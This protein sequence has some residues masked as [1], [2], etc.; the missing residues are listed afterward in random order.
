M[1]ES[2]QGGPADDW[3]T[4]PLAVLVSGGLDSA[5]LLGE[6]ARTSPRVVPIY[7]RFGLIWES[8]EE[9]TL[10]RYLAGLNRPQVAELQV[11]EV[12]IGGVYGRHWSTTDL[13]FPDAAAPIDA[14]FLP[15]RNLLLVL[16]PALWCHLQGIGTIALGPLA[17][18]PFPDSTEDFFRDWQDLI[19]R[20]VGGKLRLV[21]P[22]RNLHKNDVLR[23][24]E[25]FPLEHTLSCIRP[26][27][28][29]HCGNCIKCEERRQG[30]AAAGLPDPTR[31]PSK[32]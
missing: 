24:G 19:N 32:N 2:E 22:Y 26:R 13:A 7:V 3:R 1:I 21:T 23:R 4:R 31:Y 15:G 18:N 12:P 10:R 27:P 16:Q 29:G 30:F 6:L 8:V 28:E 14:D 17:S 20:A 11:F 25:G 5:I 9:R